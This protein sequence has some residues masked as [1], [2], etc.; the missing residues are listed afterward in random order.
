VKLPKGTEGVAL[1]GNQLQLR[2][3]LVEG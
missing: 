3:R 1:T 2:A